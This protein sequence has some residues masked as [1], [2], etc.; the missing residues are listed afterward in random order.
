MTGGAPFEGPFPD[1]VLRPVSSDALPC[2]A[3]ALS[4]LL[5]P[6]HGLRVDGVGALS[7]DAPS[8]ARLFADRGWDCAAFLCDPVLSRRHG[9]DAAFAVYSDSPSTNAAAG[10]RRADS[11]VCAEAL[12]WLASRS[13]GKASKKRS[14][15]PAF[16][17]VH[18]SALPSPAAPGPDLSPLLEAFDAS[19][20]RVFAVAGPLPGADWPPTRLPPPASA[21]STASD[22]SSASAPPA[23]SPFPGNSA[24][25]P[26]L[27]GLGGDSAPDYAESVAAWYALRLPPLG[28]PE[29]A[30]G[31]R[32]R[33]KAVPLG[34]QGEMAILK[35]RGRPGEGLVPPL[36]PD[37]AP[38]TEYG[39]AE[40]ATVAAWREASAASSSASA[41]TNG[42]APAD[43]LRALCESRPDVPL[44]HE[45]L[46]DS[47]MRGGDWTA[48]CNE[49][50]A[51]SRLGWNMVRANRMQARCHAAIGNVPAAIDRAEAAFMADQTDPLPR[52]ELADL[53]L[54]TGAALTAS[55][56]LRE[57]RGCIDRSL[58]LAPDSPAGLFER[59]RLDLAAG[60]TNDAVAGL[61]GILRKRPGY[62]PAAALLEKIAK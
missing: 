37:V 26:R 49:Y 53:L 27:L 59:A 33:P 1:G 42:P 18:L 14:S 50:S 60:A 62:K 30:R 21:T 25:A 32:D 41:S 54:R 46:A 57:A 34:H 28:P 15:T 9:L 10:F 4:G 6:D 29:C 8:A 58:L 52:R 36:P 43:S 48:A 47:F 61:R 22:S 35:A 5:P 45:A 39:E 7:S 13:S 19:S 56:K 12:A 44:F 3:S 24:D 23:S 31:L 11:A 38:V 20:P 40:L 51:A 2:A 16:V 17:W 55:G